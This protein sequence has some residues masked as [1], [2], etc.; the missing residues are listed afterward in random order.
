MFLGTVSA[1]ATG[2]TDI[3]PYNEVAPTVLSVAPQ[4]PVPAIYVADLPVTTEVAN[5]AGQEHW[6][7]NKFVTEIE[8]QG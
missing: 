6:G 7:Y 4:D 3:G 5:R 2:R 1:T 8:N